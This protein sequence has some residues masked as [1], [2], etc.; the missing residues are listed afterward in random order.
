MASLDMLQNFQEINIESPADKIIRQIRGLITSGQLEPGDKLP[1]ERKL[2]DKFGVGRGS[3]RIA[4][5]KLEF[6]GILK[7]RPQSGTVVAGMGITALEGLIS[8]VLKIENSDFASLV[9]TRVLLET[10]A[11]RL[12]AKNRTEQD[13]LQIKEAMYAYDR[14][15]Q[16]GAS[17]VEEDLMFHLKIAEASKNSVLKSLMLIITPDIIRSFIQLDICENGRSINSLEEHEIIVDHII[18]QNEDAA[19]VAMRAHLKDVLEFS[20]N[21]KQQNGLHA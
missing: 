13:I 11:A 12:A 5:Q 18:A 1:S 16:Q 10:E 15:A 8:D 3:V 6:Y 7:T 4:I 2:A 20:K 9:E 17:A 14:K 19:A 21:L